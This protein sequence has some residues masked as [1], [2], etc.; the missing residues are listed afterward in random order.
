MSKSLGSLG[1]VRPAFLHEFF[2]EN[3]W[4]CSPPEVEI[5]T[6]DFLF[7]YK[8][9]DNLMLC[10]LI[11]F[12]RFLN[13]QSEPRLERRPATSEGATRNLRNNHSPATS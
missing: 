6:S 3:K 7:Q 11:E 13:I 1:G 5:K 10:L 9:G 12:W 4:T 2:Q 8:Q